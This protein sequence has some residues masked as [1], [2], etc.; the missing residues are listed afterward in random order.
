MVLDSAGTCAQP[1]SWKIEI[2]NGLYAV[3]VDFADPEFSYT[4]GGCSLQGANLGQ[5]SVSSSVTT[6]SREVNVSEGYL[7]FG[8]HSYF[9]RNTSED[10][11]SSVNAMRITAAPAAPARP[12]PPAQSVVP[13]TSAPGKRVRPGTTAVPEAEE[14]ATVPPSELEDAE[15]YATPQPETSATLR[16]PSGYEVVG[17]GYCHSRDGIIPPLCGFKARDH[18]ECIAECDRVA[19]DCIGYSF[20]PEDNRCLLFVNGTSLWKP[21]PLGGSLFRG[22]YCNSGSQTNRVE[23]LKGSAESGLYCVKKNPNST[24]T[25]L[26]WNLE[27]GEP[28]G[29]ADASPTLLPSSNSP[30]G[31]VIRIHYDSS[32]AEPETLATAPPEAL[33]PAEFATSPPELATVPPEEPETLDIGATSET[34]EA[35]VDCV[36]GDWSAFSKCDTKCGPGHRLRYRSLTQP[37]GSGLACP[38]SSDYR[39]CTGDQCEGE[40]LATAPPR[41]VECVVGD[42]SAYSECSVSCGTGV[43][44]RSR[45]LKTVDVSEAFCPPLTEK[46]PCK[47]AECAEPTVV[48]KVPSNCGESKECTTTLEQAIL[49]AKLKW[50]D[51]VPPSVEFVESLRLIRPN[52]PDN[53]AEC[54][55]NLWGCKTRCEYP[56]GALAANVGLAKAHMVGDPPMLAVVSDVEAPIEHQLANNVPVVDHITHEE[57]LFDEW[58]ILNSTK[59]MLHVQ[60]TGDCVAVAC[61]GVRNH[62]YPYLVQKF[63]D[64]DDGSQIFD[65]YGMANW[66]EGFAAAL[67]GA[68]ST[69]CQTLL[70]A[71]SFPWSADH[72]AF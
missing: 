16:I 9:D 1:V 29:V 32:T 69:K 17:N 40:E 31:P 48:P 46:V 61:D 30:D 47:I 27:K 37:S 28:S 23:I 13:M 5:I 71:D 39:E 11:C 56:P 72:T 2:P 22:S 66:N 6:V 26:V 67:S 58:R 20:Q 35:D 50:K 53:C 64:V 3:E 52:P 10:F 36:V 44:T 63:C 8:G 24:G 18:A 45:K 43:S 25:V 19:A 65:K 60:S 12:T 15:E 42:W 14:I 59:F 62:G 51:W 34:E 41:P 38:K 68:A 49:D 4:F 7:T 33:E 21:A 55:D 70:E 57:T 54:E